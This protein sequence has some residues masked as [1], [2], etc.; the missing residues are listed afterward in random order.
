MLFENL[1]LASLA[2]CLLKG[3]AANFQANNWM[4]QIFLSVP[5]AAVLGS[6]VLGAINSGGE[7]PARALVHCLECVSVAMSFCGRSTVG[8]LLVWLLGILQIA[9]KQWK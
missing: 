3:S 8:S 2:P 1:I 4:K 9:S 6:N 5:S 7:V